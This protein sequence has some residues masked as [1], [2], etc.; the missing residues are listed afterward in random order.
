MRPF[1]VFN[2]I[3]QNLSL[4]L[5]L[6]ILFVS[7]LYFSIRKITLA[8]YFDPLHFVWTFT[9]GTSYALVAGLY[10]LGHISLFYTLLVFLLGLLFICSFRFFVS[11]RNNKFTK[12]FIALIKPDISIKSLFIIFLLLYFLAVTYQISLVGFGMFATTNRFEQARGNGVVIRFLAAIVP[13]IIACISIYIYNYKKKFGSNLKY[14]LI[15]LLLF[16]FMLFSSILNGSKMAILTYIY[17]AVLAISLYTHK[18]P[19]F[20][21]IKMSL[22]FIGILFFALFV[23]SFDIKNQNLNSSNS[24][25]FPEKYFGLERLFFR[26]VAN[27]DQYYLGLPNEVIEKINIDNIIIPIAAPIIGSTNLS[28]ILGYDVNNFNVGRQ[29]TLY[30]SPERKT[31]GGAT[32]HFDLFAY[33]YF[34]IFFSWFWVVLTALILSIVIK[35]KSF[36]HSSIFIAA[37]GTQL[38]Q[39]SLAILIEPPIGIAKI[40]DVLLIYL[41]IKIIILFLPKK[42][43]QRKVSNV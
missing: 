25:F 2:I 9:Y 34:G 36:S 35:I 42:Y 18:K 33:K 38:W 27:G 16:L 22:L 39:S 28:N 26:I 12:V 32:S 17:S 31:S 1:D 5:I 40:L 4:F 7:I 14:W 6:T 19:K 24:K 29:L 8:G 11:L 43:Y 41:F 3:F 23:Q 13:F 21:L 20:Y 30:H 10:I 37:I 15:L